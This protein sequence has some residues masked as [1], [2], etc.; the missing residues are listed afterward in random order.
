MGQQE[1]YK[2]IQWHSLVHDHGELTMHAHIMK[3]LEAATS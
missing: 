2:A 1:S 3:L